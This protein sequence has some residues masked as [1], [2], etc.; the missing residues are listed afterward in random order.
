MPFQYG[1]KRNLIIHFLQVTFIFLLCLFVWQIKSMFINK[2]AVCR[3]LECPIIYNLDWTCFKIYYM[4]FRSCKSVKY[5]LRYAKYETR[6]SKW[7][8]IMAGFH[9][10]RLVDLTSVLFEISMPNFMLVS[11]F[12]SQFGLS[13]PLLQNC[14]F[15]SIFCYF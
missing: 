4:N 11:T 15:F 7:S 10:A 3:K 9:V 1:N 8:L 6:L 12:E 5:S 13:A 14:P 2:A